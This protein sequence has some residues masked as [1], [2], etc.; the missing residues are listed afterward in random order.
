MQI[1][2]TILVSWPAPAGPI[3]RHMR[4]IGAIT[5]SALSKIACSPPHMIVSLPFSAPAWPPE[6]GASR[7]PTPLPRLAASSSRATSAE[8]VVWSTRIG[9]LLHAGKR[10]VG[11]E[12]DRA[13]VVVIADAGEDEIGILRG[14]GGRRARLCRRMRADPLLRLG[15]GAVVDGDLVP[16]LAEVA[17]HRIAHD[18]E[19]DPGDFV[20]RLALQLIPI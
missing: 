16:A 12:G 8:A 9:A 13:Q 11:A 2:L 14:L 4:G 3:R 20:D 1:W 7:K 19:T 17:R 5:G 18:A 15:R 10:A 6:T